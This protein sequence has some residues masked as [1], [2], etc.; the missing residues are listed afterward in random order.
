MKEKMD[1]AYDIC[2]GQERGLCYGRLNSPKSLKRVLA[3]KSAAEDN[4]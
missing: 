4:I 2:Q 1:L 3:L